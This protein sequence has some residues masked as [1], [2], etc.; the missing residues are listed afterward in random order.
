MEWRILILIK[1]FLIKPNTSKTID[2]AFSELG[3][4]TS[5]RTVRHYNQHVEEFFSLYNQLF[6]EYPRD[7]VRD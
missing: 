5:S 1:Q 2:T 4:T 6:Y 3:V 7:L